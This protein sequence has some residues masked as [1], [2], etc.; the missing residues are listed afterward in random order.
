[1]EITKELVEKINSKINNNWDQGIFLEPYEIPD[2]IKEPIIYMRYSPGGVSGG[3]CWEDWSD[4][5]P[6]FNREE[7]PLFEALDKFIEEISPNISHTHFLQ[8]EKNIISNKYTDWE[9]YG[10]CT[11]Y[12]IK[13]IPVSF[14]M[15][16]LKEFGYLN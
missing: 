14:V 2:N 11:Y 8:I 6:Y 3:S 16:K 4:P 7:M 9:Y 12:I 1:M 5:Q 10:N 13:Y 15:K